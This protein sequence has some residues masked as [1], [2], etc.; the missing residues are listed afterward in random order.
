MKLLI[1]IFLKYSI[2]LLNLCLDLLDREKLIIEDRTLKFPILV[3]KLY[4]PL[5]LFI[6]FTS[7]IWGCD[8]GEHAFVTV[9]CIWGTDPFIIIKC[10][11]LFLLKF[12]LSVFFYINLLILIL[13]WF[14]FFRYNTIRYILSQTTTD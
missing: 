2:Y 12:Y 9:L 8:L 11:F 7:C 1:Q 13:L 5:F 6:I 14:Y 4:L 3:V 10:T